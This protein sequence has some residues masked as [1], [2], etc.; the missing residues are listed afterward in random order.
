M[1]L[2]KLQGRIGNQ[3]FQKACTIGYAVKHGLRYG[4]TKSNETPTSICLEERSFEYEELPFMEEWRN[5]DIII[6]GYRQSWKYFDHCKDEVIKAFNIPYEKKEGWVSIH[7]RRGDYLTK[8]N[9]HPPVSMDYIKRAISLFI[10][11]GYNKFMVFGDDPDWNHDNI[12]VN[13]FTECVFEYSEGRSEL[14]DISL[15][16][17]CEHSIGSNSSYSLWIYYLNRNPYK[18][19]VFTRNWFGPDLP[20]DTRDLYPPNC[21]IL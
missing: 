14:E 6:S 9:C 2:A 16:S 12:N 11:C 13:I 18:I 8:P 17:G 21:V 1:V 5:Y 3:L 15:A 20:H 10:L 19:G 7:I 4:I